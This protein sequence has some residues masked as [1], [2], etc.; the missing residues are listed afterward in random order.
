MSLSVD[1]NPGGF[2]NAFPSAMF[3]SRSTNHG[4]MWADP[5]TLIRDENQPSSTTRTRSRPTRTTRGSCTR[6]GTGSSHRWAS[7]RTHGRSRT[8]ARSV[9]YVP[10]PP[11]HQRRRHGSRYLRRSTR[12]GPSP[13]PPSNLIVVPAEQRRLQRRAPQ[14]VHLIREAPRTGEGPGLPHRPRSAR[15]TPRRYLV[16]ARG[17]HQRLPRESWSTRRWDGTAPGTSTRRRPSTRRRGDL[18]RLA[19][20][21]VRYSFEHRCSRSLDSGLT[22]SPPIKV[23]QTP[24]ADPMSRPATTRPSPQWCRP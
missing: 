22:W 14:R 8:R 9:V 11:H 15:L 6:S 3:V 20:P 1:A 21:P 23:N 17:H 13:R 19:G 12:P 18:C 16:E 4:A 7:P 5:V 24:P 10:G 2:A